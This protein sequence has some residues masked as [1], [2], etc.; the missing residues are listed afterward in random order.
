MLRLLKSR[1]FQWNAMLFDFYMWE[2]QCFCT[3]PMGRCNKAAA[4]IRID[5]LQIQSIDPVIKAGA[6]PNGNHYWRD[7]QS[8]VANNIAELIRNGAC[9][10]QVSAADLKDWA[11]DLLDQHA[12]RQKKPQDEILLTTAQAS[13][14]LNVDRS[15][16][17]RWNRENYLKPVMIGNRCR[18]R[19]SDLESLKSRRS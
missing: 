17:W 13:R 15:T 8:K 19:Q 6:F 11:N 14:F 1:I 16:L 9:I 10:V 5:M 3:M 18:Y 2:I 4:A 7:H 12:Q